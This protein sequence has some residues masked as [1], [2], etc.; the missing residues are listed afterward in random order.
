VA[1]ISHRLWHKE[2]G[3]DRNVAGKTLTLNGRTVAIVGVMPRDFEFPGGA[4]MI[5]GLQFATK[6]DV[7]MPLAMDAQERSN[8]GSLNLA[9]I[10]RLKAGGTIPQAENELRAIEKSLPLGTVNYSVNLVPLQK[11]MVGNI[12]RLLL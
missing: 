4:N 7:W 10:G 1:I 2:F 8:Q 9:M 6:N 3:D 11:Q 5:P 12:Q